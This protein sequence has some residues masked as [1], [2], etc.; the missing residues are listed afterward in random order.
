[1]SH[2]PDGPDWPDRK[3]PFA[4]TCCGRAFTFADGKYVYEVIRDMAGGEDRAK[5]K[6]TD[7]EKS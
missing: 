7:Q 3:L 2:W 1:M 4:Y 5:P 6:P